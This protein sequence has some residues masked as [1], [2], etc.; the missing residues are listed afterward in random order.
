MRN[1]KKQLKFQIK[2]INFLV[3]TTL[4]NNRTTVCDSSS[5]YTDNLI[6]CSE[7]GSCHLSVTSQ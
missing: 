4:D 1:I 5:A 7:V 3:P 2:T 6:G